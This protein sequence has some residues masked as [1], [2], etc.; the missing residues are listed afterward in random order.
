MSRPRKVEIFWLD[1]RTE[2][3]W[4]AEE[5]LFFNV[6]MHCVGYYVGEKDA[7]T[8]IA[9]TWDPDGESWADVSAIPT[10]CILAIIDQD[11][12]EPTE[13]VVAEE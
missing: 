13:V 4:Q 8:Y 7:N 5:P 6:P 10:G 2:A 1:A 12:K 3:G 9:M 11:A